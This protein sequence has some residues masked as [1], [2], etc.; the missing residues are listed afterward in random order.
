L[1]GAF[2]AG[3]ERSFA[4]QPSPPPIDTYVGRSIDHGATLGIFSGF[5]LPKA[6][7]LKIQGKFEVPWYGKPFTNGQYRGETLVQAADGQRFVM[8]AR[9][10]ASVAGT[11]QTRDVLLTFRPH[12]TESGKIQFAGRMVK[13]I[14]ASVIDAVRSARTIDEQIDL[15]L[16]R[17]NDTEQVRGA[18]TSP[19]GKLEVASS[20]V[21]ALEMFALKDNAKRGD[22][23]SMKLD[24][25]SNT[26]TVTFK[27]N[28]LNV[29][30]Q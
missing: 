1:S 30:L 10:T 23:I 19:E 12:P 25:A 2:F 27:G 26:L 17:V 29:A 15:L 9:A 24:A 18:Q 3:A 8:V 11:D 5:Q 6:P 4:Q 22:R 7:G 14:D 13:K 16:Q 28:V 21:N 20:A